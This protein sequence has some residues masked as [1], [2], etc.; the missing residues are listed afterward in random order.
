MNTV[1]AQQSSRLSQPPTSIGTAPP[2]LATPASPRHDTP[3]KTEPR[4]SDTSS[5]LESTFNDNPN[6]GG[7]E[8]RSQTYTQDTG[9]VTDKQNAN[10]TEIGG[11]VDEA[12]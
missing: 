12:K 6:T 1:P 4:S 9:L 2:T 5:T 8:D 3:V 10:T 11:T 7:T